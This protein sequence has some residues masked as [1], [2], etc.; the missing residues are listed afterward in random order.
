MIIDRREIERMLAAEGE[1][2]QELFARAAAVRDETVGPV[3][4]LRGLIEYSNICRKNCLYCGIRRENRSVA[5]YRL[6][7]D[8]VIAAARYAG[9]RRFGSVVL[10]GGEI[11]TEDH[12]A[13]IESLVVR[14]KSLFP[15]SPLGVTLSF[16]EQTEATYRRWFRA[17]AHRYLLRIESS[18]ERLYRSIHPD[19]GLHRYE[20]RLRALRALRRVGYQVGTGVMIG[21]PGQTLADLADDIVFMRDMDIDMCGMGPYVEAEG[22]PLVERCGPPPE[23][24][25]RLAMALKMIAVLRL[26]MPDINIAAAT[27]L[28]PLSPDGRLDAVRCGANVVMPNLTPRRG[29]EAYRLY[30]DKSSAIDSRL[31]CE[32]I[33]WGEWGDSL[34][35]GKKNK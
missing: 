18:S 10:Q 27:A 21:L 12:I 11:T 24:D 17:G 31:L 25:Y 35:F 28:S 4:Y 13:C 20:E 26:A 5:R 22:T 3:L 1:A 33:G 8:E 7:P 16:G 2:M 34:R 15:A 19:D 30:D 9:E 6:T 29:K 32:R 14:I 23:R